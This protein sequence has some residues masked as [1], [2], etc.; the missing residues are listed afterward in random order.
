[1]SVALV[2]APC[3]RCAAPTLSTPARWTLAL[4]Q[5]CRPAPYVAPHSVPWRP[6]IARVLPGEGLAPE[7]ILRAPRARKDVEQAVRLAFERNRYRTLVAGRE[8]APAEI[9]RS[10]AEARKAVMGAPGWRLDR[11]TYWMAEDTERGELVHGLALV[12]VV[13]IV[14]DIPSTAVLAAGFWE[15]QRWQG[16]IVRRPVAYAPAS[17]EE[18]IARARGE[19]WT[20]PPP[21]P[22][23]PCLRCGREVRL[24]TDGQPYK[25]K[26]TE[27]NECA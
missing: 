4:C 17:L 22:Q 11:V 7:A 13:R 6:T 18:W 25:H 26:T 14:P 3:A 23:V 21:T 16:G 12:T 9:G 24:R 10:C 15:N 2:W 5:A 27:G 20:P 1:M 19:P 8:A